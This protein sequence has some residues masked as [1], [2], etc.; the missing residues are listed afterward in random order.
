[1]QHEKLRKT[2]YQP[3]EATCSDGCWNMSC[4][5]PIFTSP[6]IAHLGTLEK[7]SIDRLYNRMDSTIE[8]WGRI[9]VSE[10]P[11]FNRPQPF[12][13][14]EFEWLTAFLGAVHG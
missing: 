1:M 14:N 3:A 10:E 6:P 12:H 11:G 13:E 7:L 4:Y 5:H 2:P 8:Y 9:G